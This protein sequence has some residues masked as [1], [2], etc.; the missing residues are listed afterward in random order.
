MTSRY[1]SSPS[2]LRALRDRL[3][4]AAKREGV[5]FGRLQQHVGVLVVTQFMASLIDERGEPLLL[6]KGGAS[7]ELRRGIPES[8]TSKDLDAVI[9]VDVETVHDRLVEAGAS[10]WEGFTAV[11]TPPAA[12][13]VP[14]LITH[15]HRFTAKLNYQRRPFVSVPIEVSPVEAGN[16][17]GYDNVSSEAFAL[18]GLPDSAAVPCMT[19]PWQIAQKIHACTD[20]VDE[21]RTND[22]AHDLVDLQLLEALMID[23]PL[24]STRAACAAVFEARAKHEWPATVV[25]HPHWGPIYERALEGLEELGLAST[26]DEAV[27]R[28]QAFVDRIESR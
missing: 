16:A 19:L 14:G 23:G 25:A 20:R 24:A 22:R 12:F 26:V 11:F 27:V 2:N 17:D 7:L 1:D 9:R 6:V 4:A 28:V 18:V 3:T 13:E 8:R 15:P 21:P 10:G 5:V